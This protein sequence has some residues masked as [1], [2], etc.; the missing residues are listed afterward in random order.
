MTAQLMLAV[1]VLME[2]CGE[3]QQELICVFAEKT[4]ARMLREEPWKS[5]VAEKCVGGAKLKVANMNKYTVRWM[6]GVLL[7]FAFL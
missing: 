4:Y 6:F 1:S 7:Y 5:G 3:G 2:T